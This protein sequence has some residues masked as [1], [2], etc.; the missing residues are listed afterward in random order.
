MLDLICVTTFHQNI[1]KVL[2]HLLRIRAL[3]KNYIKKTVILNY[4]KNPNVYKKFSILITFFSNLLLSKFLQ[5]AVVQVTIV[6]EQIYATLWIQGL[7]ANVINSTKSFWRMS[8]NLNN[9]EEYFFT[10]Y[11]LKSCSWKQKQSVLNV[12]V[13][14][15]ATVRS[16]RLLNCFSDP[17]FQTWLKI[18]LVEKY[19]L[20]NELLP[21]THLH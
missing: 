21:S 3:F 10:F 17:N 18:T 11:L 7:N 6:C 12:N 20:L 1:G 8:C 4:Q 16:R 19:C 2:Y 15:M 5:K 13:V 14:S 9:R